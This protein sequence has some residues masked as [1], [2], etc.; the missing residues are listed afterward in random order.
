MVKHYAICVALAS[1]VL[2][3]SVQ[4]AAPAKQLGE[5]FG[6][7]IYVNCEYRMAA[8]FPKDPKISDTTYRDGNRTASGKQFY[9]ERPAGRLSVTVVRFN[10]GPNVDKALIERAT[11][12]L[13]KRGQVRF[14]SFVYY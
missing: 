1:S 4:A 10:D 14:D 11:D 3:F 12:V 8:Q 9:Y 2:G 7:D 6:D 5:I 13:R